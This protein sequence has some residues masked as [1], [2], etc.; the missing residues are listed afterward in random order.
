[1]IAQGSF[2]I[3]GEP[4]ETFGT[5]PAPAVHMHLGGDRPER[6]EALAQVGVN[7]GLTAFFPFEEDCFAL[8]D[9]LD[10][11]S[12]APGDGD[13]R[14][15]HAFA[16]QGDQPVDFGGKRSGRLISRPLETQSPTA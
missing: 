5:L 12:I 1:L 8:A 11:L 3:P 6:L 16:P 14:R 10:P 9:G 15:N 4:F 2:E 7:L 13:G